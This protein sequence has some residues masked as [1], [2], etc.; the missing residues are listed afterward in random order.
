LHPYPHTYHVSANGAAEGYVTLTSSNLPRIESAPPPQF[1]GPEGVWSPETL[2]CAAIADCFI[3]TFRGLSR[4][5]RF[6]WLTLECRVAGT[7]ERSNGAAHFTRYVI[8]VVLSVAEGTD[9]DKARALLERSEH[10][11]LVS[12]SL[13]GERKLEITVKV[14]S[15]SRSQEISEEPV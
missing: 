5:A 10:S 14:A 1:D 11:C 2:L 13:R 9:V 8:V 3:L 4:A 7:L 15:H 6:E 12:N